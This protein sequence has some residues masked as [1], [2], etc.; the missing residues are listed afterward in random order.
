MYQQGINVGLDTLFIF[1]GKYYVEKLNYIW[2]LFSNVRTQNIYKW[3][4]ESGH[5]SPEC[6]R[7]L[8]FNEDES[9]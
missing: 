5:K 9:L 8:S 7:Y 4:W 6:K 3:L 2:I 1:I